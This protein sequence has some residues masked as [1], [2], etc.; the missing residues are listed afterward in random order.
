MIREMSLTD[1]PACAT[2]VHA[3]FGPEISVRAEAELRHGIVDNLAMYYVYEVEGEVIGF[4]G[5]MPSWIMQDVW[6]FI[7][8]NIYPDFQGKGIGKAL[9]LHRIR[10]VRKFKGAVIHLMTQKPAFFIQFGFRAVHLYRDD[11][12]LMARQLKVLKL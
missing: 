8:I 4:A 9:T 10:E 7:W 12:Y 1:L 6:D 11:W 2:I 3:N 5:M